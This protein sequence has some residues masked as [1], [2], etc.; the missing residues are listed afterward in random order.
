MKRLHEGM[1]NDL[2]RVATGNCRRLI[3]VNRTKLGDKPLM[4][5]KNDPKCLSVAKLVASRNSR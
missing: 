3:H 1:N 4:E 2:E 5:D